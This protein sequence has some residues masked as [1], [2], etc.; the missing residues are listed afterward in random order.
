MIT[1]PSG[2]SM[3]SGETFVDTSDQF[4]TMKGYERNEAGEG[5]TPAMEDYLEMICRLLQRSS[6][7]RL[8][9]LAEQLH[10][11]PSSASKM[12]QQ[13][14]QAGYIQAG[15]YD[16]IRPT[17]R[18]CSLGAYLLRRHEVIRRF[19]TLLNPESDALEQAEKIEHFLTVGTVDCL[20]QLTDDLERLHWR[21]HGSKP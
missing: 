13:L 16:R 12:I 2:D 19:L 11:R 1:K 7:V 17:E 18:G 14:R 21:P 9:E 6:V 10:V 3:E 8:G 20:S 5:L 15:R 4:Y